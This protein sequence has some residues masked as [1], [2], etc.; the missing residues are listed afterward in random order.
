ME[1]VGII[2]EITANETVTSK[3]KTYDKVSFLVAQEGVQYPESIGLILFGEKVQ[4]FPI[5]VGQK[6]KAKFNARCNSYNGKLY[7]EFQCWSIETVL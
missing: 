5:S 2:R 7:N 6:V 3:G 4:K 1:F